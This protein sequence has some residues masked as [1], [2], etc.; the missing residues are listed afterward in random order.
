VLGWAVPEAWF[1]DL[2]RA[3]LPGAGHVFVEA[4]P[5]AI[6]QLEMQG[7]FDWIV[8][9]SLGTHL[10]LSEAE[11]ASRLGRVALLA[12]I[13]AFPREAELGGRVAR[14]QVRQLAR[15]LRREPA[16]ALA[17]FY[18]CAGLDVPDEL[19][20]TAGTQN[21]RWGLE[22]LENGS[23]RPPLPAG[24]CAWCGADDALLDV[25]RL[26]VIAPEIQIVAGAT[27]HPTALL[28]A[29]AEGRG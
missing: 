29:W 21:L 7:A 28:R 8:G 12:P 5:E 13:F 18:R 22:R 6:S 23:V 4:G 25:A 15:W 3:A 24:W 1:A 17:D 26:Q 16:A 9:Y 19:G 2:A 20:P 10:L 14:A 27:H 11:R